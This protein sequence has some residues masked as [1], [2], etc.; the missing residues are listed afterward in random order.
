MPRLRKPP[1][2]QGAL[3][4]AFTEAAIG[5]WREEP[6]GW[7]MVASAPLDA[8]DF[9]DRVRALPGLSGAPQGVRPSVVLWLPPDHVLSAPAPAGGDAEIALALATRSGRDPSSLAICIATPPGAAPRA[10]AADRTTIEEAVSYARDWGFAPVTVGVPPD[11]APPETAVAFDSAA[12]ARPQHRPRRIA[13]GAALL[14]AT[15]ALAAA[16]W[17]GGAEPDAVPAT[18]IIAQDAPAELELREAITATPSR[19]LPLPVAEPVVAPAAPQQQ[20]VGGDAAPVRTA[21]PAITET[22]IFATGAAP[23]PAE[24]QARVRLALA[25]LAPSTPAHAATDAVRAL[26]ERVGGPVRMAA[27]SSPVRPAADGGPRAETA[28]DIPPDPLA[29]DDAG[30]GTDRASTVMAETAATADGSGEDEADDT[31][32]NA[33]GDVAGSASEGAEAD[34]TADAA[35][36]ATPILRTAAP[37]ARPDRPEPPARL[38]TPRPG[39]RPARRPAAVAAVA[40]QPS[41]PVPAN[42]AQAATLTG[43]L[44]SGETGLLGVMGNGNRRTALLRTSD[45]RVQQVSRGDRVDGWTVSA[46]DANSV[47][48]QGNGGNRTLRV[49]SR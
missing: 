46:I 28:A 11:E 42:I 19:P 1:S 10:F 24:G 16:L 2:D 40:A 25:A 27:L 35:P 18:A 14:V 7:R 26:P 39:A 41:S 47:R 38:A 45:G 15:G 17:L 6:D 23:A 20:A 37:E 12:L 49:P 4:L 48:L 44:A 3:A 29:A 32:D 8:P 34:D 43:A 30:T 9:A 22:A 31:Q 5:L 33:A 13:A 21:P 36:P